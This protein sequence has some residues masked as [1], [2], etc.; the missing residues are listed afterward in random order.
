MIIVLLI[1]V[2]CS[3][4]VKRRTFVL[5]WEKCHFMIKEGIVLGRK[6]SKKRIE[7]DKAKIKVIKITLTNFV[8]VIHSFLGHASFYCRF[9]KDFSKIAHPLCNLLE[10]EV[11]F[12]FDDACLKAFECLKG[13]LTSTLVIVAP[14]WSFPFEVMC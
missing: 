2:K 12:V 4:G 10:E 3:N 11:K 6:I 9:I 8:K 1:W 5:N 14:K 13:K 7:N